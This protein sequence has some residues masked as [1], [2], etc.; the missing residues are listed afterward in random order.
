MDL[1]QPERGFSL[2]FPTYFTNF[3]TVTRISHEE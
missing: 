1:N 2:P 3:G